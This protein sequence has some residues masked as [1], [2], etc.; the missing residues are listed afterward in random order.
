MDEKYLDKVYKLTSNYNSIQDNY[1]NKYV[2]MSGRFT[3]PIHQTGIQNLSNG[4]GEYNKNANIVPGNTFDKNVL[5]DNR[6]NNADTLPG[7]PSLM[8]GYQSDINELLIQQNTVYIISSIAVSA[9][10]IMAIVIGRA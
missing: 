4:S 6:I 2:E 3:N 10:L 5:S 8:D 7:A 1:L 9:L